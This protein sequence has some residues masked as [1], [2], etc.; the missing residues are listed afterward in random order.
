MKK[1]LKCCTK[2]HVCSA[3]LWHVL[4]RDWVNVEVNILPIF[5]MEGRNMRRKTLLEN[6]RFASSKYVQMFQA[7]SHQFWYVA[8]S[9]MSPMSIC[10][11]IEFPKNCG[12]NARLRQVTCSSS[13]L[14]MK[15]SRISVS[16]MGTAAKSVQDLVYPRSKFSSSVSRRCCFQGGSSSSC[17][18]SPSVANLCAK[19]KRKQLAITSIPNLPAPKNRTN[20]LLY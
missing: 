4:P 15:I 3:T 6:A 8:K 19:P 12:P 11:R 14:P 7:A 13:L 1:W 2:K 16:K 17:S 18:S 9:P 5:Y 10:R 20:G